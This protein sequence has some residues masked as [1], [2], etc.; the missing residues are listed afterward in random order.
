M[1][2]HFNGRINTYLISLPHYYTVIAVTPT[3]TLFLYFLN[4]LV[5][6]N[7]WLNIYNLHTM[8]CFIDISIVCKNQLTASC[9]L[10]LQTT[11]YK[12]NQY[13]IDSITI[14]LFQKL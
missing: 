7:D 3:F 13:I 14:D 2:L 9:Y 11:T 1:S 6:K 10:L 4:Y 5:L 12:K 8:K